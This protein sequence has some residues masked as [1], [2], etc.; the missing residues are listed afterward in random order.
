MVLDGAGVDLGVVGEEDAAFAGVEVFAGLKAEAADV[1]DRAETAVPPTCAVGVG[2]VFDHSKVVFLGDRED[3][4]HVASQAAEVDDEDGA[5]LVGDS[6][7]EPGGVDVVGVLVDV[8]EDGGEAG[9]EDAGGGGHVG[10][11]RN[12]DFGAARQVEAHEGELEGDAA[13]VD[14]EAVGGA[15][16]GGEGL[17][18]LVD[19]A[20]AKT[21][22]GAAA[23]DFSDG[24]DVGF[25]NDGPLGEGFG[26][27]GLA[28]EEGEVTHG[29]CCFQASA[30]R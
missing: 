22:P 4:V 7:L 28:A 29:Y 5:G 16:V 8:D 15:L 13:A 11:G 23:N 25:L 17:F 30:K 24:L 21:A 10:V 19:L 1:A 27:D 12:E 9:A 26:T 2:G 3:G 18:K 14:A 6:R 20:G